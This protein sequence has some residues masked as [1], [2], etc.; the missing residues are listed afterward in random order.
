MYVHRLFP[1]PGVDAAEYSV[2]PLYEEMWNLWYEWLPADQE[3]IFKYGGY[4]TA[5]VHDRLRIIALNTNFC[6]TS[7]RR[8]NSAR[9]M[10]ITNHEAE[11]ETLDSYA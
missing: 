4:Y 11:A 9:V 1:Q 8:S 10:V 3:R 5:K 2:K 6:Y 7:K